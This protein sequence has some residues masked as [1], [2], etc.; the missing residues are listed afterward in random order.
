MARTHVDTHRNF[1]DYAR[2]YHNPHR[3]MIKLIWKDMAQYREEAKKFK[4]VIEVPTITFAASLRAAL[5]DICVLIILNVLLFMLSFL[6][7]MKYDV[8]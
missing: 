4:K 7:F 3:E 6:F 1:M 8:H 5:P 2:S